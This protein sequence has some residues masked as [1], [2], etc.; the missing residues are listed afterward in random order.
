[1]KTP[2][3]SAIEKDEGPCIV[4]A[5][6]GTGKTHTIVEKINHLINTVK[7][8]KPE[9][10]LCLTFSNGA[11]NSLKK[12]VCDKTT[13]SVTIRTFHAFCA[14]VLKEDGHLVGIDEGFCVLLPDDAKILV[15]KHL[16]ITP[17]WSNRYV[18]TIHSAKDFGVSVKD[19]EEYCA[20]L[21]ENVAALCSG[22]EM[23]EYA[24]EQRTE[25][26]TLYLEPHDTVEERRA[27][28]GKKKEIAC[29]LRAYDEYSR[30]R[31]F[32]DVW[33]KYDELKNEKN[34]LDYSD[35]N[36]YVLQLLRQFGSD[37]YTDIYKYIFVD[38]FQ[39]TNKVQFELIEHLAVHRN[40]TVV[41]DP[42]QSVY[43]FRGAYKESFEHFKQSF[44][45]NEDTDVFKLDQSYRSP[46]TVLNIA[47]KLVKN[48]Y[49]T[50]SECI[51]VQSAQN[52][53]G[54][55]VKV[56]ELA[57]SCEEARYIADLVE[58][59]IDE[60]VSKSNI[61]I[62]YRTHRQS[63]IIRHALELK[64]I[65][66]ISAGRTNMMQRR[67]IRTVV[68]YLSVLSNIAER[69]GT[70]EQ[71]WWD[72]F[73]YHN[74][75]SP[76]DSVKIG[77]YLK[78][79][80]SDDIA[81]DEALLCA[82]ED[83]NLSEEGKKIVEY[84]ASKLKK[85]LAVSNKSLPE[86]VLDIYEL[87]GLNR[88]FT[89]ERTIS[90]IE[91]LMNLRKFY[92]IAENF[93]EMH[94]KTLS[95]FIRHIE[96]IDTLGVNV[97]S[98]KVM[99]IDA[100]QMMTI[101]ATK[102]LEYDLVIVSNMAEDRFPVT[103]TR[104]EPLIPKELLPDLKAEIASWG[105]IDE[106]EKQKRIRQY[107]KDVLLY[108]ER[109]L[110]YV[111]WTRAKDK[112]VLTYA[113]SYN[114]EPDS[115]RQSVFLDEIEYAENPNCE[116]VKDDDETS[117]VMAPCS[118]YERYKSVLKEQVVNSLDSDDFNVIV[119]RI[120][121]YV[122][123]RDKQIADFGG[124]LNGI[125][126]NNEELE[127]HLLRCAENRSSLVFQADEFTFSPTGLMGYDECPKRFELAQL[128]QM[129]MRGD[130][131]GSG[132]GATTGSFVHKLF[133]CGVQSGFDSSQKF[134]DYALKMIK[135]PE[136]NGVDIDDVRSLIDVFW[137]RN[138]DK[139][140]DK[141]KTEVKLS[142]EIDGFRFYGIA[143]RIDVLA[144]GSVEIID[145]KTNKNTIPPKKR[146]WQ[147]GFYAIGLAQMGF[148]VSRLT[149]DMLRLEKPVEMSVDADGNVTNNGR[150]SGFNLEDVKNDLIEAAKSIAHD[151]EHEFDVT[152]DDNNCRFCG[153]K[154]YCPKC[155]ED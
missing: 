140:D 155:D 41:G 78:K 113:R 99:H 72:L 77:R 25:L 152:G 8:Y 85:L 39:D 127:R 118:S 76:D 68:A 93:Y 7:K 49:G 150:G 88:A 133:E 58:K 146:S 112:L 48:N 62:L 19:I 60:G 84:V 80:R 98:S 23:D 29:F 105:E 134:V 3:E 96:I 126:V 101:H 46:N 122:V 17:Y 11:T 5:G 4:L 100:V 10:I 51:L 50:E 75:L 81:I 44:G 114:S 16:E 83:V 53:D 64:G 149:L 38:E 18:T 13:S 82:L 128:L 14:D 47:H 35:L 6:A 143:D 79:R 95:D 142:F 129:P 32:I 154:F 9:E 144:D 28:R 15:H 73:H 71:S 70:G 121:N 22:H 12:K 125:A 87:S 97:E 66:V 123:C 57:N 106:G 2:Q 115:S 30:F 145:Y 132:G 40:I 36:Q 33:K 56:I 117:T 131:D 108:E 86:L 92:E 102:G 104:N 24:K 20:N 61:C 89:Y 27:I 137:E 1:M 91:S 67:E 139:Y 90:N 110:C 74:T 55:K 135:E 21:K 147:L 130:F 151:Y 138:K 109:R 148:K 153:Y 65:P 124:A 52:R 34:L 69:S 103:R 63:E 59:A 37:K 141:S 136:W 31:E 119:G 42:N 54:E 26:S 107:E 94:E 116:L 43:G 120:M 45:V 111:A